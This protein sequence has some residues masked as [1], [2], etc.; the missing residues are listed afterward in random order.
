MDNSTILAADRNTHVKIVAISLAASAAILLG[1]M[2]ARGASVD[3]SARI[4]A[5]GPAVKAGSRLPAA[6]TI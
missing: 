6:P 1:G 2:M 5:A 3:T 4:Q